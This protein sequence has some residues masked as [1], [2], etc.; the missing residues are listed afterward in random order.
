MNIRPFELERYFAAH[1]FTTPHV[2]SSS[3]CD[4]L[5]MKS[6][7]ESADITLQE[8]WKSLRLGYTESAGSPALRREIASLYEDI[9][10][11]DVLVTVPEEG[12]FL[13]MHAMLN[14]SD[15]IIC[16]L[17]QYQSLLTVAESIGCTVTTWQPDEE[18]DWYFDP[19][20]L[21]D[22]IQPNTKLIVL[23]F[24]HNP[25]GAL[26]SK[27]DFQEMMDIAKEH[28]IRIF[29]DEM[30]RFLELD[31][32]DRLPSASEIDPRAVSLFGMSKT[33]GLAG[34]RIGWLVSKDR[35]LMQRIQSLKDYT[36]IC[37]SA[38]SELL[39]FIGLKQRD[40]IISRHIERIRTN[41]THLD[42]FF[43]EFSSVASW[44]RPKAGTLC[45]PKLLLP[46]PAS[47]FCK[48]V[49][50]EAGIMLLPSTVYEYGEQHIRIGFGREN[51]PSVLGKFEQYLKRTL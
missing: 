42:R 3:D 49:T 15:H 24:P 5:E 35:E 23:N 43:T 36:T 13:A 7:I 31:T 25:T 11:D 2:L 45:F 12:I 51:F 38:P 21:R 33:F 30:Y 16:P 41:L 29:S 10:P 20:H 22:A 48:R 1:E 17:P 19:Q 8:E 40:A 46:E 9:E 39:A 4:G 37:S 27:Q 6:L 26:P 50:Q 18:K 44:V 47:Q 32:Q 34:L 14:K 28:G